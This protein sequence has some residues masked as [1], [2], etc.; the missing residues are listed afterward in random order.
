M[1]VEDILPKM[2]KMYLNRTLSSFLKDVIITDVDE[3]RK[4]ILK[5]IS[6]FKN[7]ER[8]R[9]NLDFTD[10]ER[11]VDVLNELALL[12]LV[13]RSQYIAT[14]SELV[15][16]IEA[17]ERRIVE[18]GRDE[19][20]ISSA[21]PKVPGRIY[22]AVL[23]AAWNKDESLNAHEKNILEALR[24][25]LELTRRHHRLLES[26]IGRF[27]QDGNRLHSHRQIDNALK[28]LQLKGILLRFKADD[29][30]FV[31]PDEIVRVVRYEIGAELSAVSYERLL[32][33]L[34]IAQ[35]KHI[36][37]GWGLRS[38]GAKADLVDRIIRFN[39]PPSAALSL[40]SVAD[41]T[42]ILKTLTG[43][44]VSGT[45]AERI[46]T[47][48]DHYEEI[49]M[50][51][52][53]DPTDERAIYYD[54]FEALAGREYKILRGNG[55]I[56]KDNEIERYFEEATRYLFET[57]IGA[58]VTEMKG[59]NHADGRLKYK[60]KEIVLWDNK[61]TEEAYRFPD[62]H[63]EQFLGY[64]RA[65]TLRPT[66]FLVVVTEYA[67][68]AI[69]QAH[70]LKAYS[71]TDTDVALIRAADLKFVAEEWQNYSGKKAPEFDLEVFN[72]TGGLSREML[73]DRMSWVLN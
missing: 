67:Q 1:R 32:S 65:D 11:N 47:I 42:D 20:Y 14:Y 18:D 25:Q 49:A 34:R 72:L 22:S 30:Y 5:N 51:S 21:I 19:E 3:M 57:R 39:I 71:E 50:P 41:L 37:K 36:L 66:L 68:E 31:I 26:R 17:L 40:F 69:L 61:S 48:I 15:M 60:T 46:E 38:Y 6:E 44:R 45:K 12:C 73:I 35:L 27:P 33:N 13:E 10:D 7:E 43:V 16:D 28:D 23:A 29:E 2:S 8:V 9:R 63:I 59:S 52:T 4:V 55:I 58:E 64:I 56:D 70:K 53:S 24:E 62:E 54:C